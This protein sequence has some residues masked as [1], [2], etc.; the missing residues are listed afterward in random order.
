METAADSEIKYISAID[1]K[2]VKPCY[3]KLMT[4]E[5]FVNESKKSD[6]AV[7]TS[8]ASRKGAKQ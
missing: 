5:E 3:L 6:G 8:G 4:L 2:P 1:S 7:L